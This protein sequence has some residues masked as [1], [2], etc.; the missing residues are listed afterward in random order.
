MISSIFAV[1]IMACKS[2]KDE[3]VLNVS[4]GV[5]LRHPDITVSSCS[6]LCMLLLLTFLMASECIY[7]N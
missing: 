3:Q 2:L 5:V 6:L 1:T 4:S 7:V